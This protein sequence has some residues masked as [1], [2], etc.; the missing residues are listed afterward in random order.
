MTCY[1]LI[2]KTEL[3]MALLNNKIENANIHR[4]THT[5]MATVYEIIIE[6][7]DKEYAEQAV[8][9]AFEEIDRL[10]NELSRF[11]PNSEISKINNLKPGEKLLLRKSAKEL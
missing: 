8:K 11:L 10:E 1:Y 7:D 5:A 2:T 6:Y 9:A 3:I 4:F